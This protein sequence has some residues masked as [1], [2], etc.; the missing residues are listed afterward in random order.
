MGP[1]GTE[2]SI[3]KAETL[4][5]PVAP[6]LEVRKVN[7]GDIE[8]CPRS[9]GNKWKSKGWRIKLLAFLPGIPFP[10]CFTAVDTV[11]PAYDLCLAEARVRSLPS[12]MKNK[13]S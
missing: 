1:G 5:G 11:L 12:P 3:Y 7:Y 13:K 10:L 4:Q 2:T 8:V 9:A 6:E